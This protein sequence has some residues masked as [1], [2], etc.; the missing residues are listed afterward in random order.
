LQNNS[1]IIYSAY[2]DVTFFF[3]QIRGGGGSPP[4]ISLMERAPRRS[5]YNDTYKDYLGKPRENNVRSARPKREKIQE[6]LY[7]HI[8]NSN[9]A[10][11]YTKNFLPI[12]HG[13]RN[14]TTCLPGSQEPNCIHPPLAS[15]LPCEPPSYDLGGLAQQNGG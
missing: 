1:L 10:Q 4:T 2:I 3:E 7:G 9:T 5:R 13:S 12:V 14:Q 6:R 8:T 11:G 15:T